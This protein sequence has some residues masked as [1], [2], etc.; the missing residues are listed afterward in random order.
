MRF[1]RN[2]SSCSVT[3]LAY[4]SRDGRVAADDFFF[5]AQNAQLVRNAE[6]YYR[7]MFR[8]RAESWNVR[9]TAHGADRC[10]SCS[11]ISISSVRGSRLVLWAHNSHLGD[12]RATD[13][14]HSGELNVGQ[15]VREHLAQLQ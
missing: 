7:T 5:A 3:A 6:E 4:A 2:W 14:G 8:G 10:M 11:P 13:M 1:W 12:A 9:D 15:L